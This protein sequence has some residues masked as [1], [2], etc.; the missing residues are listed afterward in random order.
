[1]AVVNSFIYAKFS[2]CPLLW[3]ISACESIRKI[4]KTQK[5]CLRIVLYDYDSDDDVL[6]RQSG[7]VTTETKRLRI[8]A[9]E[10]LKTVNNLNPNYMKDIFTPKLHPKI[11]PNDI[12]V[13]HQNT[14]TY[15]TKI[16]KTLGP[17]IL[18]Y[19]KFKEYIDTLF[20]PK[21]RCNVCMNI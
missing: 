14:I 13:K 21:C 9:I 12:L 20:R 6:L 5:R 11:R 1:M 4:E 7:K 8:L 10:I 2:Y 3:H 17:E 15:G 19:T 18:S 16:L